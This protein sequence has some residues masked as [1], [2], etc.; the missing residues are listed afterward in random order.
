MMQ[1]A[2]NKEHSLAGVCVCVC[3]FILQSYC[4]A[5]FFNFIL[6]STPDYRKVITIS[7]SKFS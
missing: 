1:L 5:L 6:F 2:E 4:F 3:V 7:H